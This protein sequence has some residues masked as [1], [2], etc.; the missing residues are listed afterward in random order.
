MNVIA[1]CIIGGTSTFGGR[2]TILGT[3]LG[4]LFMSMLS[5]SM[6]LM[7]ID[8]NYHKLVIGVVLVLAVILDQYKRELAEKNAVSLK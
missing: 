8:V 3:V 4:A 1:A 2:G 7:K 6:T 5:N